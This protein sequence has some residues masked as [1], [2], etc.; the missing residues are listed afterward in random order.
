M[1]GDKDNNIVHI[2]FIYAKKKF[3]NSEKMVEWHN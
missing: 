3:K 1:I 2:G